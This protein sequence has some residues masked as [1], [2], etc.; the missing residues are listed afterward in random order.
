MPQQQPIHIECCYRHSSGLLQHVLRKIVNVSGFAVVLALAIWPFIQIVPERYAATGNSGTWP[1]VDEPQ[2]CLLDKSGYLS[3]ETYG[4][5]ASKLDIKGDKLRCIGKLDA[6]NS[7]SRL[8]FFIEPDSAGTNLVFVIGLEGVDEQVNQPGVPSN[9]TILD[10]DNGLFFGTQGVG[11]CWT[12]LTLTLLN[13]HEVPI[14][15][16]EGELYCSSAIAQIQG[17]G[18]IIISHFHFAGGL[19]TNYSVAAEM[20]IP[21]Q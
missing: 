11:R 16:A 21:D 5:L 12:D 14:Y 2:A 20:G 7:R 19:A 17:P 1:A 3:V 8:A 13:S 6:M 18:S 4:S 9:L 15:R 10:Q